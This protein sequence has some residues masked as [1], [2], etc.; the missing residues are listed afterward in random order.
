MHDRVAG[1][2]GS[3]KHMHVASQQ[4]SV[5]Q[6]DIIIN[7]AIMTDV[8]IRHEHVAIVDPRDMVFLL[9]ATMNGHPFTEDVA[10]TDLD[11]RGRPAVTNVLRFAT[12]G[13]VREHPVVTAQCRMAG[14]RHVV[15]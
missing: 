7:V 1:N 4:H 13:N 5:D 14:Q 15:V 2:D 6:Q 3:V 10:V 9:G 8:G 12:D 11:T